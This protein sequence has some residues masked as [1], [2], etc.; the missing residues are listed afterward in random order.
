MMFQQFLK[1]KRISAMYILITK[2]N[3]HDP[4]GWL[5]LLL[6]PARTGSNC[7]FAT[8]SLFV[9]LAALWQNLKLY[10][11]PVLEENISWYLKNSLFFMYDYLKI[12][13]LMASWDMIGRKIILIYFDINIIFL[14]LT[15]D[16]CILTI[17]RSTIFLGAWII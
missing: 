8:Y 2:Y 9:V 4:S 7:S 3:S 6:T 10:D 1:Y 5:E 14:F 13:P 12:R 16:I 11:L 17:I 15:L